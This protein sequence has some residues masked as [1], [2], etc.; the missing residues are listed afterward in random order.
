[1]SKNIQ[2]LLTS[3]NIVHSLHVYSCRWMTDQ[4]LLDILR[5]I[6]A[7]PTSITLRSMNQY[8][9]KPA[10]SSISNQRTPNPFGLFRREIQKNRKK[11]YGYYFTSKIHEM[12]PRGIGNDWFDKIISNINELNYRTTRSVSRNINQ[13]LPMSSHNDNNTPNP[14]SSNR[15]T[16]PN[17]DT[18]SNESTTNTLPQPIDTHPNV[19]VIPETTNTV[20]EV[21]MIRKSQLIQK[22]TIWNSPE[23]Q[24]LFKGILKRDQAKKRKRNQGNTAYQTINNLDI[25]REIQLQIDILRRSLLSPDGYKEMLDDGDIDGLCSYIDIFQ[26]QKKAKYMIVLLCNALELYN[27]GTTWMEIC[28]CS[29]SKVQE[30]DMYG[31]KE[32]QRDEIVKK[33]KLIITDVR[34]LQLW[35]RQF[36]TSNCFRNPHFIRKG[37]KLLPPLLQRNPD[38]VSSIITYCRKNHARLSSEFVHDYVLHTAIPALLKQIQEER[39]DESYDIHQ[40]FAEHSLTKLCLKTTYNW[41]QDLGFKYE[42]RQKTYYVDNHEAPQN[43]KYRHKYIATY[44]SYE[45]RA[46]RWI[47]LPVTKVLEMRS[48]GETF[49]AN[50]HQYKD[51]TSGI[52]YIEHHVDDNPLLPT[53]LST[54][55]NLGGNLSVR[56]RSDEK[57]VLLL[58]QDESIFKQYQINNKSWT[59]PD[60]TTDLVPKSDGAGI[61]LSS[62]T[63]REFG[64][65]MKIT[66]QQLRRINEV[67]K[68]KYYS[69]SDSAHKKE[70]LH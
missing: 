50:G 33:K 56:K 58:G 44:F 64:Y 43:V 30:W 47:Q 28:S 13:I 10:F 34:T 48:K 29:L 1:M 54:S 67:R 38:L 42:P 51:P 27:I 37:K 59:L 69:D 41:M 19:T 20:G 68:G 21:S 57:P 17:I 11:H 32:C 65:G 15:H 4:L 8:F 3:V 26:L 5:N 9:G 52:D 23:A 49:K 35:H 66:P 62:F 2:F 46:H 25:R 12:P 60:G 24:S 55:C 14:S 22:E 36:R 70:V 18:A 16:R 53:M 39:D 6:G 40:L 61:M 31:M 63:S 7:L 45:R